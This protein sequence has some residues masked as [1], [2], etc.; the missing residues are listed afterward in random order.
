MDQKR[1]LFCEISPLTYRISVYKEQ[2][3]RRLKNLLAH[4]KYAALKSV[5][6][7]PVLLYR[8]NSL[9]RRKLGNVE[10]QLQENKAVNLS[11]AAPHINGIIIRPGEV[12]SF[13]R[14][15]GSCTKRKGYKEG[16]II[17]GDSTSKGI[18][19]GMC[20]FTNLIHWLVLHSPMQ[21]IEHHHHNKL[22]LFPD[23]GRQ[24]PFG[25]G[26]AIMYNYLDYRFVNP[27]EQDFQLLVYL[28]DEYLCGELRSVT[29]PEVRYHIYETD[30]YFYETD[31][32]YYRHN[33]IIKR[34]IDKSSGNIVEEK[35][36]LENTS[37]VMYDNSFISPDRMKK[38]KMTIK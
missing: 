1:K 27:T 26:T 30:A 4:Q 19:G 38:S 34:T 25:T 29:T 37:R 22:D 36:L 5:K 21:I 24:I 10:M 12:F 8:H 13:W 18:G 33:K 7:F 20:Q 3:K 11:L 35:Q 15:V 17:A 28:T 9:I 16:L 32:V 6:P 23:Y 31:G 2:T 14:L